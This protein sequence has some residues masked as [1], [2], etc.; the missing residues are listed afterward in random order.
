[1]KNEWKERERKNERYMEEK[2]RIKMNLPI[3]KKV[4]QIK[5]WKKKY[6][7]KDRFSKVIK[8][9][10][11]KSGKEERA[12]NSKTNKSEKREKEKNEKKSNLNKEKGQKKRKCV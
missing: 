3:F 4:I 9:D 5:E 8:K 2:T 11:D 6:L 1:M 7:K 10:K 12:I